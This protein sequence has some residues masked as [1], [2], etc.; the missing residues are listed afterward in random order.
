MFLTN[1]SLKRPVLA[2]VSILALVALGIMSFF[3]LNINDWPDLE[4]PYVSVTIVQ[5]GASPEQLETRVT[6][7]VEEAVAQISG[8]KHIY[9]QVHEGY[10]TVT[11]EF[12]MEKKAEVAAQDVRDKLGAIRGDLPNDIEDP[13]ISRFDPLA[14]P[15]ISLAVSGNHSTRELSII[16]D[17]VIK[18]R[19]ES[20]NG[21]GSIKINGAEEREIQIN[22]DKN[23]MA[24]WGLIPSEVVASLNKENL[25]VPAGEIN[26]DGKKIT[27]RTVGSV[28][29][30]VDFM[31][32]PVA[33]R[34]GIQLY[35][36]DIANVT[37]GVKDKDSVAHYQGNPAIGLDII[38]QSGTNTVNISA[39]IKKEISII[40]SD[41]PPGVNLDIVRDNSVDIHNSVN[42]VVRTIFEGSLLAVLTV[43]LFL[44]NWRSTII[45]AI[46]IPTSIISTFFAMKLMGFTL[47]TMSLVALSLSVGLLIDDAIVVIE[48]IV[49]HMHQGKNALAAAADATS[50][51]GLAVTATTL[52]VVA[53]F[54]PVAGMTGQVGQFFKQFGITVVFSVLVSLLV[55]FTLVPLLASRY[56]EAEERIPGGWLGRL[57]NGFNSSFNK[58]AQSYSN[59]LGMVLRHRWKTMAV[60]LTLFVGS[61]IGSS[62]LG[63]TFVPT[64][65]LNEFTVVA[66]L[67]SGLNLEAAEKQTEKL[68]RVIAGFPEVQKVYSSSNSNTANIYVSLVDG[69][70]RSRSMTEITAD[71]RQQLNSIAGAKVSM[72]Y[73]TGI[74]EE[75]AFSYRIL[76][77][78]IDELQVYAEKVHY[79]MEK[80]PGCMDLTSSFKP[81][82]PQFEIHVKLDRAADLGV[83]SGQI[84]DTLRT[85]FNGTVAGQFQEGDDRTDIRVRLAS[86]Q[87]QNISDLNNIFL[88]S[89]IVSSVDG[90]QKLIALDQVAE[91]VFGSGSSEINRFDRQQEIVISGNLQGIS[92]GEFEKIFLHRVQEELS[93]PYGYSVFAGGDSE[94]MGETFSTMG[95]A[96]I[97][98]ILFIFFILAA[99]FESYI[100]P[101]AIMLSLPMAIIGAILGLLLTGSDLSL[102]S[103]I[104]IIMLMGLVTKNAI[105]LIDFTKQ[106]RARGT[107]RNTALMKAAGIRL[108]PIL[109]TSLAMILGMIPL[110]VS[111]GSG[112]ASRSPMAYA[113]LGGLVTSTLLTLV[114]VPVIYSLLDDLKLRFSFKAKASSKLDLRA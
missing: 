63:S 45:S 32:V 15:I 38:K 48:N 21:V 43:F 89:S 33:R 11:L 88:I 61:L 113:I 22:L 103:M 93:L 28:Q 100:D 96:M 31:Q 2:T 29:R 12:V 80:I 4:F 25:D 53:V 94:R 83:S 70:K 13:I 42:D 109:M 37:D 101:F 73:K 14:T 35:I 55:S 59:F 64:A 34:G 95:M 76:G 65:E 40:K 41:L 77:G 36:K 67:D 110:A 49:R 87:R 24:A 69:D 27:L 1:L 79:I 19:L 85:M 114:V 39:A 5:A 9:S 86:E 16:A 102:I 30:V 72:L 3:T 58:L 99:Q 97:L 74:M 84:A 47:N 92:Q 111:S 20:L 68:E 71:M 23:K 91:P 104:G 112:A 10:T 62:F 26:S 50:E 7:K 90:S 17:D 57:L 108:R 66:D 105:L 8:V 107:D 6:Q 78:D 98:G 106:E 56:L 52:T 18:K 51:I 54:L 60:A 44:R 46:A 81:G 82:T 75:K